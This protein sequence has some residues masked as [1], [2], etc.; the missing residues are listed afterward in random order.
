MPSFGILH[1]SF[2]NLIGFAVAFTFESGINVTPINFAEKFHSR[3]V[4][5]KHPVYLNL[6]H[7]PPTPFITDASYRKMNKNFLIHSYLPTAIKIFSLLHSLIYF[8]SI[9]LYAF[10]KSIHC[11][12]IKST[13]DRSKLL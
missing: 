5:S 11:F 4:Y 1:V 6:K 3:H 8:T 13:T 7:F 9:L 12:P 2:K 10:E